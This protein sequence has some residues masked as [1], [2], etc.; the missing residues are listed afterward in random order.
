MSRRYVYLY[1]ER[2]MTK[3]AALATILNELNGGE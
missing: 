2:N 3:V 1:T